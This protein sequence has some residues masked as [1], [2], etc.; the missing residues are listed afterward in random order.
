[1]PSNI[2]GENVSTKSFLPKIVDFIFYHFPRE[3]KTL[4]A[5]K[6]LHLLFTLNVATLTEKNVL[7]RHFS[8]PT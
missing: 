7:F 1:M 4:K 2:Y 5:L 6:L 8:G 3:G